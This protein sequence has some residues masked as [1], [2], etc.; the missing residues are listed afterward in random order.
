MEDK[1]LKGAMF[2]DAKG[3]IVLKGTIIIRGQKRYATLIKTTTQAGLD[4]HEL[5]ISCGTVNFNEPSKKRNPKSPDWGGNITLDNIKYR[6][7]AWN[8]VKADGEHY[9]GISLSEK[10]DAPF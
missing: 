5:N 1:E 2:V 4:L 3:E 7:G 6:F 10:E 9:L 8:N